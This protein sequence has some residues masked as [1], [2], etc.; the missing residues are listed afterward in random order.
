MRWH[1]HGHE[2]SEPVDL[3]RRPR[4]PAGAHF[5]AAWASKMRPPAAGHADRSLAGRAAPRRASC[6]AS[7]RYP[8]TGLPAGALAVDA[9]CARRSS[10][11][12]PPRPPASP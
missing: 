6:R 4:H 1:D 11:W 7:R 9:P 10:G 12:P 3:A 8:R 2:G 5:D